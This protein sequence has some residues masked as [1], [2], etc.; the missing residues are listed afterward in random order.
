MEKAFQEYKT[1]WVAELPYIC[2]GCG[3]NVK[4]NSFK[5]KKGKQWNSVKCPTCLIKWIMSNTTY[6]SQKRNTERSGASGGGFKQEVGQSTTGQEVIVSSFKFEQF[7]AD[8][9][10]NL[11]KRID[12]LGIFLKDKFQ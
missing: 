6:P 2:E 12:D 11:N 10:A 9:F 8:E 4:E 1:N 5:D 3:Q 7:V